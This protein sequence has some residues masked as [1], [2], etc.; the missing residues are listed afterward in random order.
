M[1]II[2]VFIAS[3][4]CAASN[5]CMRRSIDT[6]GT[7]RAFLVIQMTIACLVAIL[8]GPVKSQQFSINLPMIV[9]GILA[10]LV[11]SSMLGALGRALQK[12][13]PGLTFSILNAS[14]VVPAVVM[15]A[16]FGAA[17]GYS[18]TA[19]HAIG[20]V[21]V[22]IGLFW[23][24][25]GLE[26]LKDRNGWLFFSLSMFSLHVLLLVLFQWRALL[27]N[28]QHPE[29]FASFFS[30][31]SIRSPWFMTLMYGVAAFAQISIFLKTENR[32]PKG[33]EVINGFMGGVTN[34]VCT[35]F[36]I[37]S[38][39]VASNL[40]NAIIYPVFSV[41]TILLSNLW[42]E[43]VYQEQVNW[44]ACQI[45]GLGLLIGTIDWKGVLASLGFAS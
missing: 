33:N 30:A 36:L 15:A 11:F 21:F 37:W 40:E 31:E 35:Y 14:T 32:V 41:M 13:P 42:S 24:G 45:C 22:V 8:L 9:F 7:T 43:K 25:R 16:V 6:G 19:W 20:S 5:F 12:G 27:L 23:A 3:I 18:Y 34:S 26:G 44:R 38:T 10:G 2:L 29:E 1:G 39:E 28:S 4:F 17:L